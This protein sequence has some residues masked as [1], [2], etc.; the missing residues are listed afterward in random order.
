MENKKF[1]WE[2]VG[3]YLAITASVFTIVNLLIH[4]KDECSSIKER[5]AVTEI[6][7]EY[8]EKVK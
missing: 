5:V 3:V 8:I 7:I 1:N 4:V 6:K 2:K